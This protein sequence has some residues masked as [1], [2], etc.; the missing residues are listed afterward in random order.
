VTR[1]YYADLQVNTAASADEIKKQFKKLGTISS[2]LTC[3]R[4]SVKLILVL[5]KL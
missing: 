5:Y 2:N 3:S 4:F 1:N